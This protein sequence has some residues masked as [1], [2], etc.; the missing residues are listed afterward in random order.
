MRYTKIFCSAVLF[1]AMST[2]TFSQ[3]TRERNYMYE[4]LKPNHA[5]KPE[6]KGFA[7][8]RV[9]ESL[10]R[11]LTLARIQEGGAI[12]ISW[13]LL[14]TDEEDVAFN[15]YRS[16]NGK[17]T[18]LN[19]K[20]ITETTDFADTQ[21]KAENAL[22]W[23][24]A[25]QGKGR[26][27][28]EKKSLPRNIGGEANY[29]SIKLKDPS[30]TA[31]RVAVADLNGDG[32][33]DYII[34]HPNS[35]VDPGVPTPDDGTTYKIEAYLHDGTYLWTKDLGLG[36]EPGV[37]YSP[38]IVYDFNGDGKAEVAL[39]TAADD[40][41][42]NET[43]RIYEGSEYLSVLDGMTGEEIARVAWP[44]RN[45]RYGDV[46]RQN[47]NQIGMAYLDGKTPCIL[48]ARGTYRLMVVDA[49]QLNNGKL[50]KLWRWDGDEENPV[51]RSQGAHNMVAGDV[52]GDG[53]DEILLGSCMLNSNGTLRWSTGLGH[54]DKAYLTD[55]DPQREGMEVFLAIEPWVDNGYGVS[56]VDAN[57]GE[58]IWGVGHKTFHVGD[59]MV[60]D[61]D[62]NSPG[63]ECFASED[64]KG[65]S[66]DKYL[67][68]AQG[69]KL[70]ANED[71]P[72]C[73]NWIWWGAGNIRQLFFGDDNRWGAEST[74]GGRNQSIGYWQGDKIASGIYGDIIMIAD[75]FGDWR[76]EVVTA[77]PGE[78]RIYH[79]D[80]PAKDRK[81]TLM[82]DPIYRSYV[83][84]RSQGYPQAPVPS[85]YLGE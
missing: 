43:G 21:I 33:Y 25:I 79:T 74:S 57:T 15:V 31:G 37:W 56:T 72:P 1:F 80:I 85:Y 35:N 81:V 84:Q 55:I 2:L 68:S 10:N 39:K 23:V 63:L 47:R 64:K 45:N 48:A 12:H 17:E 62:P 51:V 6:V 49:W 65:G 54:S 59:G 70:G 26:T 52:D 20:P 73:R 11:G 32:Q 24:E 83:L 78:L 58:R 40:Y 27:L 53:K 76:E 41:Q 61:I 36:I 18:K 71:V 38:F 16:V 82:Q 75:L 7:Q 14:K 60:A 4:I 29:H 67:L 42:K 28:S 9:E 22:Y 66:T 46:N 13:R 19:K 5:Q 50:E 44:E 77:L 3:D 8:T 69:K 34:R 30:V